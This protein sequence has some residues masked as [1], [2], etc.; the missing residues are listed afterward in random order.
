MDIRASLE[1]I[2]R[3]RICYS[4][5]LSENF[6]KC[7]LPLKHYWTFAGLTSHKS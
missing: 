6:E 5:S 2:V 1:L 3:Q 4:A 7:D